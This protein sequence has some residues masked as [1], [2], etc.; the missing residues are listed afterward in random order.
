MS[1]T[2]KELEQ[3]RAQAEALK[4][5]NASLEAEVAKAN[6]KTAPGKIR[7]A[8]V[9]KWDS[10]ADG[11]MSRKVEFIDGHKN[12]RLNGEIAPTELVLKAANGKVTE[13][14]LEKHQWLTQS[15]AAAHLTYLAQ[16]GYGYLK[17]VAA[18]K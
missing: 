18:K 12:L 13:K 4:A 14:D 7:G 8:F 15:I 5:R 16:I 9:A 2:N 1:D 3:A 10:P 11:K 6:A 17:P